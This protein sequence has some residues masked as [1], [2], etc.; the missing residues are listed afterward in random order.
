MTELKSIQTNPLPGPGWCGPDLPGTTRRGVLAGAAAGSLAGMMRPAM[1]QSRL[2]TARLIPVGTAGGLAVGFQSHPVSLALAEREVVLTFDDGPVAGTTDRVLDVLGAEGVKA[3][4]FVIGRNAAAHPALCRRIVREGHSLAHH[5]FS[6]PWTFRRMTE[7]AGRADILKGFQ[8]VDEAGFGGWGGV[9][10]RV[11]FFRYPGFADTVPLNAWLAGLNIGI[12]GCDLWAS[13][14][15]P[16]SPATQL[17]LVMRRLKR[18]GRGIML[19]HD[20]QPQTALMLPQFLRNLREQNYTVAHLVPGHS[21]PE[22]AGAGPGW[23]SRTEA[24]IAGLRR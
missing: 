14:W 16:M 17:Q 23:R 9:A 7:A 24:I 21:R 3:T 5:S 15:S 18:A 2:G 19:F 4:F 8:A 10:P 12:F 6:H 11:P 13:D 20:V 1:A 22:L